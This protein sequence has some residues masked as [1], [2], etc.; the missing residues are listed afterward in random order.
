MAQ[1]PTFK[2]VTRAKPFEPPVPRCQFMDGCDQPPDVTVNFLLEYDDGR[3]TR[4]GRPTDFCS[5]HAEEMQ[6]S[7]E[8]A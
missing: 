8:K 5:E 3:I 6:S 7:W 2:S 4:C 1:S